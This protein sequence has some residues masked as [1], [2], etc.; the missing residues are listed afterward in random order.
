MSGAET[1][2]LQ[3]LNFLVVVDAITN[4][5]KRRLINRQDISHRPFTQ[6]QAHALHTLIATSER[7]MNYRC[8]GCFYIYIF[9]KYYNKNENE[10]LYIHLIFLFSHGLHTSASQS[11][12]ANVRLS[13]QSLLL[14]LFIFFTS[15]TASEMNSNSTV[16]QCFCPP[17]HIFLWKQS[18]FNLVFSMST[19]WQAGSLYGVAITEVSPVKSLLLATMT[20]AVNRSCSQLLDQ[21]VMRG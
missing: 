14:P 2:Q 19:H 1:L 4:N 18:S 20:C 5:F 10:W 12:S 13:L 6:M 11:S 15:S 17:L 7:K 9:N 8:K 3:F 21:S 16:P